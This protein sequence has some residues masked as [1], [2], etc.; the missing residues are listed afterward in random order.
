M[1]ALEQ[2]DSEVSLSFIY[3]ETL[4]WPARFPGQNIDYCKLLFKRIILFLNA[5]K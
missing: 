3:S 1:N 5:L 2:Q 4:E